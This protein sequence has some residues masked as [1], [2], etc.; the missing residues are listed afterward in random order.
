MPAL[1]KKKKKNQEIS[2]KFA[3]PNSLEKLEDLVIRGPGHHMITSFHP[4]PS[5]WPH[6]ARSPPSQG[7]YVTSLWDPRG[8]CV[9]S[10]WSSRS[11]PRLWD[12]LLHHR[13]LLLKTA[14]TPS[15]LARD[16]S[17]YTGLRNNTLPPCKNSHN[18]MPTQLPNIDF[19]DFLHICYAAAT[20]QDLLFSRYSSQICTLYLE[21]LLPLPTWYVQPLPNCQSQP[22]K[23]SVKTSSVFVNQN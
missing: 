11:C 12:K 1:K 2:Y 7:T 4:G 15:T 3:F 16:G 14:S 19:H 20:F 9:L 8:C 21:Y 23:F 13:G 17:M 5:D 10:F 6:L 18:V 22:Q